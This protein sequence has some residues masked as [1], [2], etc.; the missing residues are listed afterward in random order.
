MEPTHEFLFL[1]D[2]LLDKPLI[3]DDIRT[4]DQ[5]LLAQEANPYVVLDAD[6]QWLTPAIDQLQGNQQALF[7]WVSYLVNERKHMPYSMDKPELRRLRR[8]LYQRIYMDLRRERLRK[9]VR[10]A[11]MKRGRPIEADEVAAFEDTLL[12]HWKEA[13]DE[14]VAANAPDPMTYDDKLALYNKFWSALDKKLDKLLAG[15]C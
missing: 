2:Q 12:Y 4:I 15:A 7:G 8:N 13:R 11:E 6:K 14:Y 3:V 9:G 1:T 10:I 5:F